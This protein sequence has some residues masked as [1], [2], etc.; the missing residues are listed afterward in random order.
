MS[1]RGAFCVRGS[2]LLGGSCVGE[3]LYAGDDSLFTQ[4]GQYDYDPKSLSFPPSQPKVTLASPDADNQVAF[5]CN[6]GPWQYDN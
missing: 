3:V 2:S 1:R 5:C 4:A 6:L